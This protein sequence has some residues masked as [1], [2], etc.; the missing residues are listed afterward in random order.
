MSVFGY[1]NKAGYSTYA[2]W[3]RLWASNGRTEAGAKVFLA[4]QYLPYWLQCNICHKWRQCSRSTDM[5]PEFITK[6]VC[7]MNS[8]GVK[9]SESLGFL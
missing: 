8:E 7:G 6:Y 5:T 2:K 9:V 4:D 1:S 3:R